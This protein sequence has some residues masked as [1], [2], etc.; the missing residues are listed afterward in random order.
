MKCNNHWPSFSQTRGNRPDNSGNPWCQSDFRPERPPVLMTINSDYVWP[1]YP[2]VRLPG[3]SCSI[4]PVPSRVNRRFHITCSSEMT[5]WIEIHGKNGP[6][7][8][9]QAIRI[10][11]ASLN[12]VSGRQQTGLSPLSFPV[13]AGAARMNIRGNDSI[14]FFISEISLYASFQETLH[15]FQCS[16]L[17]SLFFNL[18]DDCLQD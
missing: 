6:S 10:Q 8:T 2:A 12:K 1:I 17:T 5:M 7:I 4:S 9:G 16:F 13:S 3:L 14:V 18:P 11:P 15:T